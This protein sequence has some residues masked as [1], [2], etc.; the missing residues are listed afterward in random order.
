MSKTKARKAPQKSAATIDI[1]ITTRMWTRDLPSVKATCRRAAEAAL[2]AAPRLT[3]AE[4]NIL[5]T[6]DSAVKKLNATYRGKDK[7]T[8]VLSFPAY[9]PDE[10]HRA[11]SGS[12]PMLGDIAV[13]FGVSA[14][15]AKTEG[16]TLKEHL[17]HL[18]VHG[19]LHLLG[20]DHTHDDDA[21]TMERRETKILAG[22][23]ISDPYADAPILPRSR[24]KVRR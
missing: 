18:V 19:V 1:R 16:K 9:E 13:A 2:A 11:P 24:G 23:G 7:P 17:S 10:R 4:I 14:R 22:L 20:Y 8:N 15:E 3:A 12:T 5:L 6:P 21:T